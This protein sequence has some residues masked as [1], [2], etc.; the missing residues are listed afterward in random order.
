MATSY[1]LDLI[2]PA[3]DVWSVTRLTTAVKR[4][5]EGRFPPIWVRGEVSGCKTYPSGHWYFTL[6]DAM[7]QVRCCMWKRDMPRAAETARGRHRGLRAG[8]ARVL[9]GE[10]RIPAQ[11]SRGS[12][13]L[14]GG[15]AQQE[16]ERVKALLHQDGLFDPARKRSMPGCAGTLAVVTST[17]GAALRD[18]ITVAR[19]RWPCARVLVVDA[20]VQG[21][22]AV[23]ELVRALR[24]VN[25]LPGVDVCIVGRGG[26]AGRTWR[27]STPRRCVAPLPRCGCP[28]SR[29]W[30]TR[31]TSRSRTSW[32][33]SARRLRPP[34]PSSPSR[35]SAR[36][37]ARWT[38][39]LPV[40]R[41]PR[42]PGP[43]GPRARGP[44]RRPARRGDGGTARSPPAPG[45][46]ALGAARRAEPAQGNNT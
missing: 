10:G 42:R 11:W 25:R 2:S 22:G 37:G 6:R 35:T 31:P 3:D 8:P 5:V 23:E 39:S 33:T 9:R 40:G 13:R 41:R 20:R 27:R 4:M 17:A 46:P 38:I 30:A 1:Q 21:D 14:C 28:P 12:C 18:I 15:R 24:L 44:R 7:C 32:P 19:S 26:G 29:P 16:L 36:S 43:A 34:R 45:G